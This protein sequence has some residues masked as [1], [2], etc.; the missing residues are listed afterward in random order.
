MAAQVIRSVPLVWETHSELLAPSPAPP[1]PGSRGTG[2][3][4]SR[5]ELCTVSRS[6]SPTLSRCLSEP[7]SF[8]ELS[9]HSQLHILSMGVSGDLSSPFP[10]FWKWEFSSFCPW[11]PFMLAWVLGPV[12]FCLSPPEHQGCE[13]ILLSVLFDFLGLFPSTSKDTQ[14]SLLFHGR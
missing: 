12:Y 6:L 5:W 3:P 1:R 11:S 9:C 13:P 10:H 4:T 7:D 8:R 2:A 14:E